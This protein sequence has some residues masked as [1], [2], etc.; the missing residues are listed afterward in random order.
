V[1]ADATPQAARIDAHI[2]N[3]DGV[4]RLCYAGPT[5]HARP[6]HPLASREPIQVGAELYGDAA[7]EADGEVLQLAARSLE[8][9]GAAELR[10]DLG[11]SGVLRA[12]LA[13][14]RLA[15]DKLDDILLALNSRTRRAEIGWRGRDRFHARSPAQADG[16]AR[17]RRS[18]GARRAG[19]AASDE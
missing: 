3:R 18:A 4:V 9:A 16:S 17:R 8:L 1:R 12:I 5:L 7:I 10:I 13:K 14:E 2:L 11:H 19:A 6:L 15:P